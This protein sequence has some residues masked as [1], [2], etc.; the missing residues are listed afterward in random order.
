MGEITYGAIERYF[1]NKLMDKS[2]GTKKKRLSDLRD[3]DGWLREKGYD[4]PTEIGANELDNY[5]REQKGMGYAPHTISTRYE[6]LRGMYEKLGGMMN[7]M[8]ESPFE[9]LSRKDYVNKM[10]AKKDKES[11]ENMVYVTRQELQKL[12]ENVPNPKLR[13]K[14][15]IR[16]MFQTGMRRGEVA[17]LKIEHVNT[18]DREIEVYSD[19]TEEWRTVYYNQSLDTLIDQWLGAYRS[20]NPKAESSPYF[21]ITAKGKLRDNRV[22]RIV[23]KAAENAGIQEDMYEDMS[24][25]TRYRITAHALRHGHGVHSIKCGIDPKSVQKHM[26][27]KDI[28]QTMDYVR[29]VESDVRDSYRAKWAAET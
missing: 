10:E 14:L 19:K 22:N 24:E 8:E 2:D 12:F 29:L 17:N 4:D 6:T 1:E 3:F 5:F 21:F 28:E 18:E 13:N 9:D 23:K 26:G 27:H 7:E 20:S 11:P 16:L 25:Q 15:M